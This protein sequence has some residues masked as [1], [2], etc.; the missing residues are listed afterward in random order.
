MIIN[1]N[2]YFKKFSDNYFQYDFQ[3]GNYYRLQKQGQLLLF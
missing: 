3:T 2:T 1:E